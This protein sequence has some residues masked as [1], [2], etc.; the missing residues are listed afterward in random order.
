MLLGGFL[1]CPVSQ[2]LD[3][4]LKI[5]VQ[6]VHLGSDLDDRLLQ[7]PSIVPETSGVLANTG[8]LLS[9]ISHGVAQ[10]LDLNLL[11][12]PEFLVQLPVSADEYRG[13]LDVDS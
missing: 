3:L 7:R 11:G 2:C 4:E 13:E 8:Y 10:P 5:I 9:E 12:H 1:R 6:R